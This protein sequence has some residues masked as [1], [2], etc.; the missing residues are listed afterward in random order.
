VASKGGI[1]WREETV[2]RVFDNT[3]PVTMHA[4][5]ETAP[6]KP[7]VADVPATQLLDWTMTNVLNGA[8][9]P[10]VPWKFRAAVEKL[11]CSTTIPAHLRVSRR[12]MDRYFNAA[13]A[14]NVYVNARGYVEAGRRRPFSLDVG[15]AA[16]ADA[17]ADADAILYGSPPTSPCASPTPPTFPPTTFPSIFDGAAPAPL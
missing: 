1:R 5:S 14:K 16:D 2:A 13:F 12:A 10:M 11:A 4:S 15:A 17:D 8:R 3:L 6:L 9:K 7:A